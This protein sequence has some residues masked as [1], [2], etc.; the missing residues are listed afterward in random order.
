[1][2]APLFSLDTDVC[3]Y[4][5]N[6]TAPRVVERLRELPADGLSVSIVTQAELFYGALRSSRVQSNL[7]R[8]QGFLAPLRVLPF[9][10]DATLNFA[11]IKAALA[12][13][14]LLIGP[15]DLLIAATALAHDA[16]LVTNNEREFRRVP[17]L[18]VE[19]WTT[20]SL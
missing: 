10:H 20:E 4:L 16:T 12:Q 17:G 5:M 9:D 2:S 15:M 11:R 7:D 1:M 6:G 18:R 8:V 13:Q 14:G 3:I 19:N